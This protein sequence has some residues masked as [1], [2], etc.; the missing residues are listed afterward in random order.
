MM[1]TLFTSALLIPL[2]LGFLPATTLAQTPNE[3]R[4]YTEP[5]QEKALEIYRRIIE[6]RTAK[7]HG[8]VPAMAAWLADQF[9]NGGFPAEDVHLLSVTL[10]SGEETA[11]LVVRY[12]GDGSS[13]KK[14]I[15]LNAHMDVVDA[16]PEDWEK[17]PFELVEEDGYFFG[18]GTLDDKFGVAMLS[19]TFLRLKAENFVP[20]RD[21]IIAFNG[22]EE[23]G[24]ISTRHLVTTWRELTDAEFA[25]NADAGGGLFN[26]EG[27]AV[28]YLLQ[29]AEKTF[30][31]F[32]LTVRN[33]GGHS[34]T[35]RADNAI[36]ELAGALKNIEAFRFPVRSNETTLAYFAQTAKVIPGEVGEAMGRFAADPGDESAADVLNAQPAQVGIIRTTCVATM[37]RGG[38]AENALPQ[39]ATATVNCRIFP[40]V[41]IHEVQKMLQ[42]AVENEHIEFTV[43]GEPLASAASPIR[44]DV[45]SAV[46]AAVHARFPGTPIIPYQAP[47]GTD[48]KELR[49]A[50]IPTYGV[51]GLFIQEGDEFAHGLD[52]R[53]EVRSFFGALEHWRVLLGELAGR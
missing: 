14:P 45:H 17:N 41:E 52:E 15:L 22:D 42:N 29:T 6:W 48:G 26:E 8:Q 33:P 49:A 12:R 44:E 40:G 46:T 24:M 9:R 36:Y 50:G 47:Y 34:S 38:H 3:S 18:R 53:V 25:L 35:P 32:E 51:M 20:T 23:S 11:A 7:G 4:Y 21:L 28:A 37:L 27:E 43:L 39:S 5:Y 1:R 2:I 10:D 30:A 19:A 31:T 16:L 13:G